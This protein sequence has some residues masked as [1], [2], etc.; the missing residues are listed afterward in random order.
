MTDFLIYG[1]FIVVGV[2]AVVGI[3]RGLIRLI[4]ALL[5]VLLV[6]AIATPYIF[7]VTLAFIVPA[8]LFGTIP[9]AVLYTI[10]WVSLKKFIQKKKAEKEA[11]LNNN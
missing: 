3:V 7:V 5:P 6:I 9:L 4:Q 11:E 2:L 8:S 10:A 1:G